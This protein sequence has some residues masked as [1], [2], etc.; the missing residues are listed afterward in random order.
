VR[1]GA[2]QRA[3]L[4]NRHLFEGKTV[5]DVGSG[6]GILC[7]F[8]AKAGAAKVIGIECSEI[9]EVARK[10]VKSNG[11]DNVIEFVQGKCEE[12]TLPVDKVDI[13]ISEWMG[14]FL[15]YESMLDTVIFARDKWLTPEGLLFPDKASM[16]IA[17]IEDGDYKEE[18]IGF[19]NS[20]Y[21]FDFSVVKQHV[22]EEPIVDTVE[23]HVVAT[24]SDCILELDLKTCTVAQL[25]FAAPFSLQMKR[26][27][28][29]HA[30]LSWFDISFSCCHKPVNFTT[31]PFGRYTHWKQT[32]F[33]A[34]ETIVAQ[35]GENI[36]GL[37]AV[38]KNVKNPRDLDI[39]LK[40][41]FQG[42]I[43]AQG[44]TQFYP[45]VVLRALTGRE[46]CMLIVMRWIR[47]GTAAVATVAAL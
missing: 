46:A 14:Y 25:D 18:K 6:T 27:D 30:F 41:E 44:A 42:E 11:L 35:K 36:D 17:G 37:I 29:V 38:R 47:A 24:T 16:H 40:Y 28:F 13:I 45:A 21:G 23:E 43:G 12:V 3:I 34:K 33:Y 4:Q 22:M 10:I 8:A 9:V 20:V 32:V 15:L 26:K 1:T 31:G 2:Y 5:L 7:M 19:W 39:K